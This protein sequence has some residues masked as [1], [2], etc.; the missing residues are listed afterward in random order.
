MAKVGDIKGKSKREFDGVGSP[1]KKDSILDQLC[2]GLDEIRKA[3]PNFTYAIISERDCKTVDMRLEGK[4]TGKAFFF[5][6]GEMHANFS[7]SHGTFIMKGERTVD[8][9]VKQADE[10]MR[11]VAAGSPVNQMVT[12]YKDLLGR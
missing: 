9:L 12:S 4:S 3:N 6:D 11:F 7:N 2:T 5:N 8:D 1:K 10:S